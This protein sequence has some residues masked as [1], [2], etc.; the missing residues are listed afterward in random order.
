MLPRIS[1]DPGAPLIQA[2]RG[3]PFIPIM[4]YSFIDV[5]EAVQNGLKNCVSSRDTGSPAAFAAA[6]GRAPPTLPAH[7]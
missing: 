2:L 3:L 1:I 7:M 6:R 4:T 5:F